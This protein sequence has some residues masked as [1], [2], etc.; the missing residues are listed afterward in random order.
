[1]TRQVH[2][3]NG[4]E[5]IQVWPSHRL[6]WPAGERHFSQLLL[7]FAERRRAHPCALGSLLRREQDISERRCQTRTAGPLCGARLGLI[8]P[9]RPGARTVCRSCLRALSEMLLHA[10]R[11][12]Q[13]QQRGRLEHSPIVPPRRSSNTATEAT[14]T[15]SWPGAERPSPPPAP[16]PPPLRRSFGRGTGPAR[17]GAATPR[18]INAGGHSRHNARGDFRHGTVSARRVAPGP[19]PYRSLTC[20]AGVRHG[21]AAQGAPAE[22]PWTRKSG[23]VRRTERRAHRFLRRRELQRRGGREA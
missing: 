3:A 2:C 20:A 5:S 15:Q 14:S 1:M 16:H 12:R 11:Q 18:P 23:T 9:L 21:S 6:R 13:H 17:A 22:A 7:G 4:S 10:C 19:V 8:L